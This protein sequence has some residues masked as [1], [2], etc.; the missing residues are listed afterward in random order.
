MRGWASSQRQP[1]LTALVCAVI[2]QPPTGPNATDA[3]S[4]EPPPKAAAL[5]EQPAPSA[6][7]QRA[8]LRDLT[9]AAQE[10]AEKGE[11]ALD[12]WL[13]EEADRAVAAA[14]SGGCCLIA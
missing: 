13:Q 9:A 12:S 14:S 1:H 4:A 8:T 11:E 7:G 5:A 10:A 2:D 6:S 3:S